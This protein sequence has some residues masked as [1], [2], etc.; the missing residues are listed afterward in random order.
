MCSGANFLRVP[1]PIQSPFPSF[2]FRLKSSQTKNGKHKND[3]RN[4]AKESKKLLWSRFKTLFA[5]KIATNPEKI[6]QNSYSEKQPIRVG[7]V[8]VRRSNTVC[9]YLSFASPT[10]EQWYDRDSKMEPPGRFRRFSKAQL[11]NRTR[12]PGVYGCPK[13]NGNRFSGECLQQPFQSR[14]GLRPRRL[15]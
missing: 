9:L 4:E 14:F 10:D 3:A 11:P 8:S 12:T 5:K 2:R 1:I 13:P 7:I 6:F 15:V